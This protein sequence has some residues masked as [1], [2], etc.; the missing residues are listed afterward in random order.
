MLI[1]EKTYVLFFLFFN[2]GHFIFWFNMRK[3][4][5]K[6]PKCYIFTFIRS[7][8]YLILQNLSLQA[9]DKK[10]PT[11]ALTH[12][13]IA[14]WY[15]QSIRKRMAAASITR[16]QILSS[17]PSPI[18]II[19]RSSAFLSK[20]PPIHNHYHHRSRKFHTTLCCSTS[21]PSRTLEV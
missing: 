14:C 8:I 20:I 11:R 12:T 18:K 3:L 10:N 2:T 1:G 16:L 13:L 4:K 19:K 21:N 6:G 17:S 15:L 7:R 5:L 9:S